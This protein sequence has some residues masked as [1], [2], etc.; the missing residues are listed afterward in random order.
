MPAVPIPQGAEF[1]GGPFLFTNIADQTRAWALANGSTAPVDAAGWPMTDSWTVIFDERAVPA[2]APPLD[3]PWGW[4]APLNGTYAFSI[5]GKASVAA[6][7]ACSI[8]VSNVTFDAS[9]WTTTGFFT[10]PPGAPNLAVLNFTATQRTADAPVGSGFTGLRVLRPGHWADHDG[11]W[12][13]ELLALVAPYSHLRFMGITGTNTF[14]GYYGDPG[15]HALE[16][17]DRC[18]PSDAFWPNSLRPGCWGM[19]W[20]HVVSFAQASGKGVWVNTPISATLGLIGDPVKGAA[21]LSTYVG[22]MAAL[23]K[24][25]PAGAPIYVEHS[26]EIWNYGFGQFVYNLLASQDECNATAHPAAPPCL[27]NNDGVNNPQIWAQRR[28]IG[29]VYEISRTFAAV[30]GDAAIGTTV[31]PVYAGEQ[32]SGCLPAAAALCPTP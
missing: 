2:W 14:P 26:N 29:K 5:A 30:F 18:L 13:P 12:S 7:S 20:E 25:V 4:Q 3:D 19:P 1:G 21:N 15:H 8:I 28:H 27:W 11:V 17:T 16:W 31:R 23:L 6:G 9:T 24:A 32:A 10:L 22:H